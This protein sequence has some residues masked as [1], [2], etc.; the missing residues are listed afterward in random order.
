MA[1]EAR[2][3]KEWADAQYQDALL[4]A[5]EYNAT[6]EDTVRIVRRDAAGN[7]RM[8]TAKKGAATNHLEEEGDRT[9]GTR[10]NL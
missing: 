7:V 3:D 4:D 2:L 8:I 1:G 6:H 9:R 10:G 5:E